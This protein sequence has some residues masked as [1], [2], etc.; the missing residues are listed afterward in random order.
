MAILNKVYA[1]VDSSGFIEPNAAMTGGET[2][3]L[4]RIK[5]IGSVAFFASQRS[6]N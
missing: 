5:I 4:E 2:V 3:V 6:K 1:I